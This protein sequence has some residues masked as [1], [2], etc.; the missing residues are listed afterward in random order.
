MLISPE[1]LRLH[2]DYTAWASGRLVDAAGQLTSDELTRDFG[3]A[4]KSVLGTL[5]HVFAADRIWRARIAGDPPA[6]FIEPERD[7]HLSVLQDVWPPL[8][9][10]WQE[11][12]SSLTAGSTEA[13]ISWRDLK[14]NSFE[15]PAWQIALHVVNHGTHHRGQAAGFLRAL[16][17]VPPPLD[18]ARHYRDLKSA[19]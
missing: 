16:G 10:K 14:G 12:V 19:K 4:D 7:M 9:Q 18:L 5:V 13:V 3:S 15:M 2:L 17:K 1:V 6:K 11:W 8:L